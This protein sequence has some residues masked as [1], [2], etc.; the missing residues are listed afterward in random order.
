MY[1]CRRF[2]LLQSAAQS[3]RSASKN[4]VTTKL[5]VYVTYFPAHIAGV[6]NISPHYNLTHGVKIYCWHQSMRSVSASQKDYR[7]VSNT[8]YHWRRILNRLS[9]TDKTAL[10]LQRIVFFHD[11]LIKFLTSQPL[12]MKCI[13]VNIFD[14]TIGLIKTKLYIRLYINKRLLRFWWI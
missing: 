1:V 5:R 2:S 10:D 14:K 3:P 13:H 4:S 12:S 9:L 11:Y 8:F 7:L 6:I